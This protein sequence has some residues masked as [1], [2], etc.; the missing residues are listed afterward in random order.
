[1]IDVANPSQDELA[2]DEAQERRLL[3]VEQEEMAEIYSCSANEPSADHLGVHETPPESMT[4]MSRTR[5]PE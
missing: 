3:E 1:M 5:L 4:N 2:D